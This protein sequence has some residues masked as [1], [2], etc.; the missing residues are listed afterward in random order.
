MT[1]QINL[2]Q[3]MFRHEKKMFSAIAMLQ[4][5]LVVATGLMLIYGYSF[6]TTQGAAEDV[7]ILEASRDASR[8]ELLELSK[9]YAKKQKSKLLE[10][11]VEQLTVELEERRRVSRALSSGAFGALNGFGDHLEALARQHVEGTWLTG[12]KVASG[13]RS[14]GIVGSAVFPELIP[15][16]IQRLSGESVFSG[17]SF[18]VLEL[19]RAA[20]GLSQV[21]FVLSSGDE[22]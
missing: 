1:Q 10:K 6:Y 8:E 13:G 20:E 11:K 15:V 16:Y 14:V 2:Y 3:P 4:M 17:F 9:R 18:N 19:E 5:G 7:K 22:P 12:V 21:N